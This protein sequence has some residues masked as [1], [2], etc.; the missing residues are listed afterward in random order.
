MELSHTTEL[1]PI[2]NKVNWWLY[3]N[4]SCHHV[5]GIVAQVKAESFLSNCSSEGLNILCCSRFY[6]EP[7]NVEGIL[8]C[9]FLSLRW[10]CQ[11]WNKHRF[12]SGIWTSN[13]GLSDWHDQS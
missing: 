13:I 8:Y 4:P 10:S 7:M 9:A 3:H 1:M 11:T 12:F 5:L 2:K 6:V